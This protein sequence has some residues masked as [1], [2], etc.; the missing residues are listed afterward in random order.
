MFKIIGGDGRQ[1]GPVSTEQLRQWIAQGRANAQT[2]AQ[3][4]GSTDWKRLGEFAE[5]SPSSAPVLPPITPT[6]PPPMPTVSASGPMFVPGVVPRTNSMAIAGLVMGLIGVTI[7]WVCCG[8]LFSILGVVFSSVAL[9]QIN[10]DPARQT[11]RGLAICGLVLSI[12][13][14]L[15]ALGLGMWWFAMRR[16][17]GHH[18]YYWH[19]HT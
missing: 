16:A 6:M 8:P 10:R 2:L 5:F 17:L 9:S 14:L 13:G 18:L 15:V 11:G 12:L 4:E 3:A 19:Y 7:G 1:Y